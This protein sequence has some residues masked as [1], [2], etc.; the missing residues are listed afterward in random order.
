MK[1]LI[2]LSKGYE[3]VEALTVVD[4]L[5]RAGIHIDMVATEGSL[6]TVGAHGIQIKADKLLEDVSGEDYAMMILP[7]G[8]G[9]T[10]ALAKNPRVLALL[11]DQ[12]ASQTGYI[13][14]ICASPLVLNRAGIAPK[15]QGTCYPGLEDQ[16][17]FRT[18]EGE[19]LVVH[20]KAYRV[21]TSPGPA[22]ALYFA[23][24]IIEVLKGKQARDQVAAGLLLPR[25]EDKLLKAKA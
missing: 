23:L 24:E 19:A 12:F 8:M 6:E 18:Y 1:T 3:E 13:A 25:V 4:Y 10:E 17:D 2:F 9:G 14:S 7:G 21:I 11:R 15:I 5:R 22:T 16:V 20:D